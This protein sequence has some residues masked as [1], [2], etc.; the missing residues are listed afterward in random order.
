M[1]AYYSTNRKVAEVDLGAALL[2]GQ[3]GDRGLFMPRPIPRFTPELLAAAGRM[4]YPELAAAILAPYAEGVFARD[5]IDEICHGAYDFDVPLERVEGR[6]HVMRLDRGP[7]A[8]FKDFA[9]KFMGRALGRLVRARGKDLLILTATSGDTGSAIAHAFHGVEAIRVLVL[10]PR[11]EVSDRQRRQMT[12]LGGNIEV[13]A[14]DGK[15]DDCQALV[16]Q[17][18]SDPALAAYNLSS[19]NSINIGRL[20]PQSVYYLWAASRLADVAAGEEVV[21]SIPS[22]NFGD[23]MGG[24]LA[25]RMGLP[26]ARFVIATN[27][28]DEVPRYLAT[29][30]YRKIVPSRECISNAMNVGHPSNLARV[31]DLYGGH[32]DE[33]GAVHAAPDMAAL[34]RDL[35]AVSIDDA[36]TRATIGEVHRQHGVLL[37]PHGA[38]GWAGLEAYLAAHPEH[39]G[40]VAVSLETAH[41]AKFPDEVRAITGVDPVPPPS[42]AGLEARR[43]AYGSLET[44]EYAEFK[45]HLVRTYGR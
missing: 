43:E 13:L 20:L 12:T 10:F 33:T 1:I 15:F 11:A 44:V 27:A 6:R 45:D 23:M 28:N 30:E 38:V 26:V 8:S 37:E 32:M 14:V 16:K 21:F 18:F 22:G 7:T 34:R 41:P 39:A 36:A 35:F 3:A 4:P 17:A 42:L 24:L 25:R 40:H 2:Q 19:A 9:A 29:G 5:V 31:V